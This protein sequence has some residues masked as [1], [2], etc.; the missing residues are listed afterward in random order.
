MKILALETTDISAS[1]A[2]LDEERVLKAVRL[3]SQLR[4]AQTLVPTVKDVLTSLHM[5]PSDIQLVAVVN[6]PGSFTGLR[7]GVMFARTFCYASGAHVMDVNTLECLAAGV[8]DNIQAVSAVMDA[9]RGQVIFQNFLRDLK[10]GL[11]IAQGEM[12][13]Q[14]FSLWVTSLLNGDIK[15]V[16]VGPILHR[17]KEQLPENIIESLPPEST[18]DPDPAVIGHLALRAFLQGKRLSIWNLFPVYSRPSAAEERKKE[19]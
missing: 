2:I 11:M 6:G 3:P 9:Q 14:D 4:S 1:L 18:W 12:M 16:P 8:P 7:V 19:K 5:E 15:Y 10:T 13:L 17:K